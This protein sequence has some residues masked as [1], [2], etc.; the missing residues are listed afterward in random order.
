MD[1]LR[2]LIVA[3]DPLARAGL[4]LLLAETPDCVVVGQ[5]SGAA[6]L[7]D[8]LAL[9]EPDVIVWDT[10]WDPAREAAALRLPEAGEDTPPLVALVPDGAGVEA[11]WAQSSA[12]AILLR[13]ASPEQIGAAIRAVVAGLVVL[14]AGLAAGLAPGEPASPALPAEDLTPR[15]ME[16]LR[17]LAEGLSNRAIAHRLD[18]SE[19]TVKFHV[20]AIMTKLDAQSRTDAVVRATRLGLIL[21]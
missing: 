2:V 15:E 9:Y 5:V 7:D 20:N 4:A 13:E 8:D 1:T 6:S 12:Q 11:L 19:H 3:D 18:I 10:G 21:L 14:D 17:L 16:V